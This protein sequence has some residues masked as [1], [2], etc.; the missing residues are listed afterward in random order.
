MGC[1]AADKVL[2]KYLGSAEV[3][4]S[5]ALE[6]HSIQKWV[7]VRCYQDPPVLGYRYA[8]HS[9]VSKARPPETVMVRFH[10]NP[11]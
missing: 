11:P 2:Q 1:N 7:I 9:R 4:S 5:C 6:K 10:D 8:G 3:G